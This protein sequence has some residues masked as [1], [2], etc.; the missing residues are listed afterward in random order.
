MAKII[1]NWES[2]R[3]GTPTSLTGSPRGRSPKAAGAMF[4]HTYESDAEDVICDAKEIAFATE[5]IKD[6]S[7]S[8]AAVRA[9]LTEGT[10]EGGKAVNYARDY[11]NRPHVRAEI[12]RQVRDQHYDPNITPGR[13][14]NEIAT[15][16]FANIWDYCEIET[17]EF[18]GQELRLLES[19]R[20]ANGSPKPRLLGAAVKALKQNKRGEVSVQL[21]EKSW[22]LNVLAKW[23][24]MVS[25]KSPLEVL[26]TMLPD[27]LQKE[28]RDAIARQQ[29]TNGASTVIDNLVATQP[30]SLVPSIEDIL[31]APDESFDAS[32]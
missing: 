27:Y 4:P 29:D 16:A 10:T 28:L 24:G 18:G 30:T 3:K 20:T 19:Y 9:G 7:A 5:Y 8:K 15:I 2:E 31:E 13:V 21:H 23:M 26:M 17:N 11:I 1:D 12:M 14:I 25:E 6:W 32:I 22:A